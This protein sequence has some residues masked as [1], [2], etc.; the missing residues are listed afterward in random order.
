MRYLTC[1]EAAEALNVS[2][3][4]VK[5]Y[6]YEGK[7]TSTKL[8]GG[9][10]RIAES[11]IARLLDPRGG[12]PDEGVGAETDD[13]AGRVALLE[14]WVTELESEVERLSASLQVVAQ[15]L[16]RDIG[17]DVRAFGPDAVTPC[18]I[19]V[20]GPGCRRCDALHATVSRILSGLDR[21]DIHLRYVKGL[22]EISAFG[23]ILTPALV[24]NGQVLVS[25]RIPKDRALAEIIQKHL[26]P[27]G[28][29]AS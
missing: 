14:H 27:R 23:P 25:G 29:P 11:E 17:E 22:D 19:L 28:G 9:R 10:H 20:L 26:P 2:V 13:P 4:T 7:I 3:P 12:P 8:P 24:V 16:A 6:I 15:Y 21:P 18:E 1:A 5:R